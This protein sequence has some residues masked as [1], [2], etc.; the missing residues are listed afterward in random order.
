M[1]IL[2][3]EDDREITEA[4]SLT[5]QIFWPQTQ[6][7][8]S[9]LGRKGVD[10]AGSEDFDIIILDLGLPDISGFEVL[11]Q[12]RSFSPVPVVILTVKGDEVDIVKGLEMGADDYIVKPCGRMELLARLKVR[13]RDR[14][15]AFEKPPVSLGSLCLD[16]IKRQ[17]VHGDAAMKLTLTE[18]YIMYYLMRNVGRVVTYTDLAMEVWGGDYPGCRQSLRV[19]IRRLREKIEEDPGNPRIILTNPGTGY[20]MTKPG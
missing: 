19:H 14:T 3:I 4:I 16:P 7:A 11:Q 6:L 9:H 18:S 13:M 1:K 2:L 17:L 12:I 10:L 8:I 5:L 20:T 15:Q